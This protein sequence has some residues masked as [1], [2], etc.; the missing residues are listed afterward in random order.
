[1]FG[2]WVCTRYGDIIAILRHS[3]ASANLRDWEQFDD[4]VEALGGTGPAHDMHSRWMFLKNPPD[5]TRRRKLVT[6][7]FTPR[8]VENRRSHIPDLAHDLLDAVQ[9]KRRFDIIQDSFCCR[10]L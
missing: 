2:F 7:A 4:Y 8:V 5:H 1:M 10:S 9:A 6:E 3:K